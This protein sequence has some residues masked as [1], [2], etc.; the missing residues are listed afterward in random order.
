MH[1]NFQYSDYITAPAY[2]LVRS[3]TA[4]I[5]KRKKLSAE[6]ELK[7]ITL[8]LVPQFTFLLAAKLL[9]DYIVKPIYLYAILSFK[10]F[11]V[12]CQWAFKVAER[13][14]GQHLLGRKS[15][16]FLKDLHFST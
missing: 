15:S 12:C 1:I 16:S 6:L 13:N 11:T 4:E 7:L 9:T 14:C 8:I 10:M 3:M 5:S 2:L